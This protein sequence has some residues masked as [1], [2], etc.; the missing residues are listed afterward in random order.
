MSV[1]MFFFRSPIQRPT[2]AAVRAQ[3][4][5]AVRTWL[6]SLNQF[7]C[8][9]EATDSLDQAQ[10]LFRIAEHTKLARAARDLRRLVNRDDKERSER[11]TIA[12]QFFA[13]ILETKDGESIIETLAK[14]RDLR[15]R[16]GVANMSSH[17]PASST[18][19]AERRRHI[20]L[21]AAGDEYS[22][23]TRRRVR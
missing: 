22:H 17:P 15:S 13:G 9:R 7:Q 10:D 5:T 14:S 2:L 1:A 19:A 20:A 21:S 6:Q 11:L 12:H 18:R 23:S 4:L 8:I 16:L 3:H